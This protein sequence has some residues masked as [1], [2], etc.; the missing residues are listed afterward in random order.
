MKRGHLLQDPHYVAP[1]EAAESVFHAADLR[2]TEEG[3][4]LTDSNVRLILI[5]ALEALSESGEPR[6]VHARLKKKEQFYQETADALAAK[7][8]ELQQSPA[9][10]QPLTLQDWRLILQGL[11]E[12]IETE[13]P[14][15]PRARDYLE[16]I[17]RN[18]K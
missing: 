5:Q 7:Y 14:R 9:D 12:H 2:A 15:V 4:L 6:K 8:T 17:K 3:L 11:Q 18:A 10:G 16:Q 13:S 1:L